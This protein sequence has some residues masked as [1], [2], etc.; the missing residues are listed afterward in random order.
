[1]GHIYVFDSP[2]ATVF[3]HE[4]TQ[5]KSVICEIFMREATSQQAKGMI[6]P[7]H[8]MKINP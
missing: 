4:K 2:S 3:F 1:M 8:Y 5:K 6:L 7:H